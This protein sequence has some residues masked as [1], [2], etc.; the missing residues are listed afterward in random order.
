MDV[1]E[2]YELIGG[3]YYKR[4]KE[5]WDY[6]EVAVPT[7]EGD[8]AKVFEAQT[9]QDWDEIRQLLQGTASWILF[10]AFSIPSPASS[11]DPVSAIRI[12]ATLQQLLSEQNCRATRSG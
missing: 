8:K 2:G 6:N 5:R 4:Y 3:A 11:A 9:K 1:A 7:C 10:F 12:E